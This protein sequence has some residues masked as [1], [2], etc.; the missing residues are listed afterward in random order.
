MVVMEKTELLRARQGQDMRQLVHIAAQDIPAGH[1]KIPPCE[2]TRS[3]PL[4]VSR[5]QLEKAQY[6]LI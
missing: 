2:E 3:P 5:T 4:E 1:K 6:N